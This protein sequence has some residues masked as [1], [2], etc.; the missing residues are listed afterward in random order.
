ME[1]LGFD[2]GIACEVCGEICD[3]LIGDICG[4]CVFS[5]AKAIRVAAQHGAATDQNSDREKNE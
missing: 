3:G 1:D 2:G 5:H 4:D